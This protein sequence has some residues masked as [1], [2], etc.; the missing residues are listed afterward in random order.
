MTIPDFILTPCI[1]PILEFKT[2]VYNA[3]LKKVFELVSQ[4][5]YGIICKLREL[6]ITCT[7]IDLIYVIL[8]FLTI[9]S[10]ILL[11]KI[12]ILKIYLCI[13]SLCPKPRPPKPPKPCHKS[14][15]CS[16]SVSICSSS[17]SKHCK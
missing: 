17:N 13:K 14:S 12:A 9:L 16:S 5:T 11:F 3:I 6:I 10:L 1:N 4:Y 7:G 15:S 2:L 8:Y